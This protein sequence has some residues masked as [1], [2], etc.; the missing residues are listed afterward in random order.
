MMCSCGFLQVSVCV[1]SATGI[2]PMSISHL[3][4]ATC[5]SAHAPC[6]VAL[7]ELDRHMSLCRLPDGQSSAFS[8]AIW[9]EGAAQ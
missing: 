1:A 4:D 7:C 3:N 6:R 2:R 8:M 5:K 9:S